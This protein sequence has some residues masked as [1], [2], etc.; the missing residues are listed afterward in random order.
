MRR[1]FLS[2]M[3]LL[4]FLGTINANEDKSFIGEITAD[5]VNVRA[6]PDLNFE[7]IH[8]LNRGDKITITDKQYDWY[9]IKLPESCI[10]YINKEY[11]SKEVDNFIV[12]VNN[13]N[14]RAGASFEFNVVGKL[15]KEDKIEIVSE[16][17]QW[18]GIKAPLSCFG[19]INSR[20]VRFYA[21]VEQHQQEI[22]K[23]NA[24]RK[25]YS[26][27]LADYAEELKKDIFDMKTD[28]IRSDLEKFILDYPDVPEAKLAQEKI[29][30]IN[31]K[32]AEIEHLKAKERLK[33]AEQEF[34]FAEKIIDE[35]I[36]VINKIEAVKNSIRKE[37]PVAMGVIEDVGVV[38]HRPAKYKLCDNNKIL[39][40]LESA[41]RINLNNFIHKKVN[42]WGDI[43]SISDA[44]KK[45][46]LVTYLEEID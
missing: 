4:S 24:A 46:L 32:L 38:L 36:S 44:N 16:H 3:T 2:F 8:S 6:G 22:N 18:Y 28:L 17:G 23:V 39:Y 20:Y 43:K 42:I 12:K 30:E 13:V 14:V 10:L 35:K 34:K 5:R 9:K 11:I 33:Q 31:L 29:N 26:K 1:F 19:W 45:L 27:I 37:S 41:G 7:V 25:T 40:Y 21:T 15:S